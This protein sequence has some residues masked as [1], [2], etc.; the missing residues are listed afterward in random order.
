MKHNF[1]IIPW[2]ADDSIL[3]LNNIFKW[4]PNILKRSLTALEIGGGNST[5]YLLN[6]GCKVTTI[7]G[8]NRYID[9]ITTVAQ[10]AGFSVGKSKSFTQDLDNDLSIIEIDPYERKKFNEGHWYS[11]LNLD[12][13]ELKFDILINDGI[14]R[15]KFLEKF[16]HCHSSLLIIDNCEV[17]SNW[18][19]LTKSSADPIKA[20]TYRNF[21]RDFSWNKIIFE[22][23]EGRDGRSLPDFVGVESDHRSITT[24]AWHST[25]FFNSMMLTNKGFPVVNQNGENDNDLITL[26]DR[27]PYDH[28]NKKWVKKER[29]PKI[30]NQKLKRNYD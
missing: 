5:L 25:H 7:E 6:K 19:R 18:G 24:I 30:L 17:A 13:V 27:F 3:F 12:K 4:Y 22:Q 11:S 28:Q 10:S 26:K 16:S 2:W 9:Y 8:D 29:Y 15:V 1:R 21:L 23:G 20:K 14:D